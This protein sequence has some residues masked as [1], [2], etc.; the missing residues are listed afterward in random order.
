ML[1]HLSFW[2]KMIKNDSKNYLSQ[3]NSI[4]LHK[5]KVYEF[6]CLEVYGWLRWFREL[7][8]VYGIPVFR[9]FG[10]PR[11]RRGRG[12]YLTGGSGESCLNSILTICFA[13]QTQTTKK[14]VAHSRY[15]RRKRQK[16]IRKKTEGY[17]G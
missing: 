8:L 16:A 7:S 12:G 14:E 11:F 5:R 17:I 13:V 9:A 1:T 10:I 15:K 2:S 4:P 3:R 6:R